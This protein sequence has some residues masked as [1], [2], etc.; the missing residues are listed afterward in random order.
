M[1]KRKWWWSIMMWFL[2]MLLANLYFLYKKYTKMHDLKPISHLEFKQQVCMD[3]IESDNHWPK[4]KSTHQARDSSVAS[5]TRS[6]FSSSN[7]MQRA[8]RFTDKS[9]H[10]ITGSLCRRLEESKP[11][12]PIPTAKLHASCQLHRWALAGKKKKRA[13]LIYCSYCKA[14]LFCV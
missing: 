9:L 4:N 7:F 8:P 5:A 14:K 3:W 13:S 6:T 12:W 10:P 11:H 1:S 2:Q